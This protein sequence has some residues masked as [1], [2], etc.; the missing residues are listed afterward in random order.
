MINVSGIIVIQLL[1]ESKE[2]NVQEK[3]SHES[4]NCIFPRVE[5]LQFVFLSTIYLFSHWLYEKILAFKPHNLFIL[6]MI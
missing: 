2:K 5:Y 4:L 1:F 3:K 6:Q